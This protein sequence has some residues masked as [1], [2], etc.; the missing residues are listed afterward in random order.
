MHSTRI[1]HSIT[2]QFNGQRISWKHIEDLYVKTNQSADLTTQPKLRFE[3]IC[4][5]SYSKMRVDLAAQ[6]N[7]HSFCQET[8]VFLCT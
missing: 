7:K 5:T 2:L 8:V 6:V 4:L 3:H 1:L